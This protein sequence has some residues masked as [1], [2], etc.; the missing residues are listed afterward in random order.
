MVVDVKGKSL[1]AITHVSPTA[2]CSPIDFVSLSDLYI[3]KGGFYFKSSGKKYF[4]S[5]VLDLQHNSKKEIGLTVQFGFG[6]MEVVVK[7]M[8][9]SDIPVEFKAFLY[10]GS[11]GKKKEIILKALPSKGYR[12]TN[13]IPLRIDSNFRVYLKIEKDEIKASENNKSV[14]NVSELQ[15]FDSQNK[16]LEIIPL[17]TDACVYVDEEG[18]IYRKQSVGNYGDGYIFERF[19][20]VEK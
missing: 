6:D 9:D 10:E 7:G 1:D 20:I 18:T 11:I 16:L 12:I 17:K 14:D 3:E 5:K 15:V 4:S 19:S 2:D 13:I 8:S